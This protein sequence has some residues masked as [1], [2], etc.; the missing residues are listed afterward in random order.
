MLAVIIV[1]CND[2][3]D[4]STDFNHRLAFSSDTICFDTLFTTLGSPRGGAMVYNRN[5]KDL[6]IMSAEL[7]EGGA[8]GFR[9]M[10]DGQYGTSMRDLEVRSGDSLYVFAE[11][12][13]EKNGEE[14]PV[15]LCDKLVFTL[16]S[17][18]QQ[19]IDLVAYGRDVVFMNAVTVNSDSVIKRGHYVVYESLVVAQ[20]ATLTIEAGTTLYFH[21]EVPLVVH[22]TLT[23]VGAKDAPIVFRGDRTDRIFP[24]LPYDR[25]PGQWDGVLFTSTS[26]G[27][28]LEYCDVHSANYGIKIEP[29]DAGVQR[30]AMNASRLENFYGHAMEL[31]QADVDVTN[32][33]IANAGGNC[34]K[35]VGGK[36]RFSHCTI[37]NFFVFKARDVALAL[38]NNYDETP[39]PLYGA[40]FINCIITGSGTDEV[41]GYLK[42]LG[43]DYPDGRNY[44]FENS[45]INT[46]VPEGDEHFVN[47]V[48]DDAEASPFAQEHFKTIDHDVFYY[49]F[50]LSELSAARSL[51]GDAFLADPILMYDKDGVQRVQGSVDAGCYLYVE[52]VESE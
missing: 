9:V 15:K 35:V 14:K 16:E 28:R 38:H 5:D 23:A 20:G 37:A 4:F 40:D 26:N 13:P 22:G 29:G 12:T 7:A 44:Y 31:V 8:S 52:P 34:V 3:T 21:D 10:V 19:A 41:M 6:R 2:D 36:V 18:A 46:V 42:D 30:L 1:A 39:A 47:I 27:N 45:L 24:Y 50:H 48:V 43:D 32:S 33:L 49:D 25:L 17:G 51:G 11:V